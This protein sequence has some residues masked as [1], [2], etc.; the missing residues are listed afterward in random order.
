MLLGILSA[1]SLPVLAW[2]DGHRSPLRY[3]SKPLQASQTFP[4]F[5]IKSYSVLMDLVGELRKSEYANKQVLVLAS[6]NEFNAS[7]IMGLSPELTPRWVAM[8]GVDRIHGFNI[9]KAFKADYIITTQKPSI[10]LPAMHQQ[11]VI[12]PSRALYDPANPLAKFYERKKDRDFKLSDG[13]IVHIFKIISYPG[14]QAAD[15]LSGE[16]RKYYPLWKIKHGKIGP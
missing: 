5:R 16:F 4:P 3:W 7:M 8:G 6:S 15:W 14:P 2:G 10:H 1:V 12:I 9:H 13:N 11:V